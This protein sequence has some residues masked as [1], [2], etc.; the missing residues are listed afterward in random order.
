MI[1]LGVVAI[2]DTARAERD[3]SHRVAIAGG[4][5]ASLVPELGGHGYG[6]VAYDLEHLPAAEG[7]E[8]PDK[9]RCPTGRFHHLLETPGKG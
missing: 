6:L 3:T 8:L 5:D 2:G 4:F 1:T 7:K 9:S